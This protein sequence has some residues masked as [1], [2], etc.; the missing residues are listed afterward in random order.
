MAESHIDA[1]CTATL[2]TSELPQQDKGE[3]IKQHTLSLLGQ[4]LKR[5]L[6]AA[7]REREEIETEVDVGSCTTFQY[8]SYVSQLNDSLLAILRTRQQGQSISDFAFSDSLAEGIAHEEVAISA[9]STTIRKRLSG[10][11]AAGNST[12]LPGRDRDTANQTLPNKSTDNQ[13]SYGTMLAATTIPRKVAKKKSS[14]ASRISGKTSSSTAVKLQLATETAELEV[15]ERFDTELSDRAQRHINREGRK[16]EEDARRV[17]EDARRIAEEAVRQSR[18]AEE[19]AERQRQRVAEDRKR[20]QEEMAEEAFERA[21][22]LRR[23]RHYSKPKKRSSI[24]STSCAVRP[25]HR[26]QMST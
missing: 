26:G 23:K 3:T 7:K 21:E 1:E 11:E 8:R 2:E 22:S 9:L 18:M 13:P 24:G 12:P 15:N 6:D 4:D 20:R 10:L 14:K 5:L 25:L 17:A 19:E 16:A